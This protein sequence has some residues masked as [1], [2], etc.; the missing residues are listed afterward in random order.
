MTSK[1]EVNSFPRKLPYTF[2]QSPKGENQKMGIEDM[3]KMISG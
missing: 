3:P 2:D 1:L